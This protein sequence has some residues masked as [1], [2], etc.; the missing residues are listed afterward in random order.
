MSSS[1]PTIDE[2]LNEYALAVLKLDLPTH[3]P[4]APVGFHKRAKAQLQSLVESLIQEIISDGEVHVS[5]VCPRDSIP[6]R[7]FAARGRL[8]NEQRER[9]NKLIGELFK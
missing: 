6:C 4:D 2:V 5:H 1:K 3:H 9:A 7:E 8:R